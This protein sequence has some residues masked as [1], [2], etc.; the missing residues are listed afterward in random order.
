MKNFKVLENFRFIGAILVAIG[1]FLWR[2]GS[3]E[4]FCQLFFNTN[5]RSKSRRSF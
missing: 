3:T 5:F 1:H 2:F 4:I